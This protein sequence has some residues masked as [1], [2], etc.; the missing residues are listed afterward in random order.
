M[1]WALI[2][3]FAGALAAA[4]APRIFYS[5]S[6]PGSKPAYAQVTLGESGDGEFREAADDEAPLKFRL[7]EAETAEVFELAAKLDHFKRPLESPAKVAFMGTK[8]FRWEAE[9]EKPEVKFNYSDSPAAQA[10]ADWF[11]RMVD[12]AE[13]RI[14]LETAAKYD[15]L[16]VDQALRDL[17]YDLDRKR[18]VAL[19]QFLPMLDRVANNDSYMHTARAKAAEM[20]A[21]IRARKP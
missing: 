2:L 20:A 16:G 1:K 21:E 5:K 7:T 3:L 4:D 11:E 17:R 15:R 8:T 18:M 10:L 9:G 13:R 19:D 12:S 6:F 14:E